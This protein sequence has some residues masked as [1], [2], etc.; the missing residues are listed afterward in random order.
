M[1]P[2]AVQRG[3]VRGSSRL[4]AIV[5]LLQICSRRPDATRDIQGVRGLAPWTTGGHSIYSRQ[6]AILSISRAGSS[7]A[8]SDV[9]FVLNR[10]AVTANPSLDSLLHAEFPATTA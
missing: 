3:K 9:A 8:T 5:D 2:S 4:P 6:R 10:H 1:P 7:A